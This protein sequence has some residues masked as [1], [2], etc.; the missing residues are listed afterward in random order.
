M[1]PEDPRIEAA[2]YD[3]DFQ[4]L[5]NGD[6]ADRAACADEDARDRSW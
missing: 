3:R 2:E 4:H 5:W 6:E 1:N